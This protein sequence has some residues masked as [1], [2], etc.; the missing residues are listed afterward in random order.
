VLGVLL[1]LG[2]AAAAAYGHGVTAL[3]HLSMSDRL[4]RLVPSSF[5]F[6]PGDAHYDG[7]YFYAIARDPLARGIAHKLIDSAAYRYGHPGYG[8]L[9]WLASAGGRPGAI[10]Y[11]LVLVSLLGLGVACAA[12]SLLALDFGMSPWWGLSIAVNPGCLFAVT[13]DTSETVGVALVLVAVLLWIRERWFWAGV[14]IAIGCLTKEPLLLVPFALLMWEAVRLR[15]GRRPT[16]PAA[17]VGALAI[18]PAL[19]GAWVGYCSSVFGRLPVS[20]SHLLAWPLAG[21]VDT[22]HRAALHTRFGDA[23]IGM[24]TPALLVGLG[25]VLVLGLGLAARLE[26]P[27]DPVFVALA[28]LLFCTNW[29]NLLFPK[30]LIR[31]AALPVALLP[32]VLQRPHPATR[33]TK[34]L[35]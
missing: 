16:R 20:E 31:L 9:A 29:L 12:A 35:A 21:W 34:S 13:V 32:F 1:G 3:V 15:G 22:F 5:S 26:T 17:R 8:W 14:V 23:Q 11:A 33:G 30:D 2:A 28:V 7:V 6:V 19:Y 27:I 25:A 4:S 24:V 10:P 18:G